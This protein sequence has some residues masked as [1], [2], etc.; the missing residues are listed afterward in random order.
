MAVYLNGISNPK[1]WLEE[2][3]SR[4]EG[5]DLRDWFDNRANQTVLL[6]YNPEYNNIGVVDNRTRL[7]YLLR[8]CLEYYQV[9][10][11][12]LADKF[13]SPNTLRYILEDM[14]D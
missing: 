8:E 3:G 13:N 4:V 5:Y 11:S 9:P 6:F 10:A 14:D 12:S 2:N 1:E 7:Q